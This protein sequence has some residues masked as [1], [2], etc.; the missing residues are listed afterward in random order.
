[1]S[2]PW[3]RR[4]RGTVKLQHSLYARLLGTKRRRRRW[5]GTREHH[6]HILRRV[7]SPWCPFACTGRECLPHGSCVILVALIQHLLPDMPLL[8]QPPAWCASGNAPW[9]AQPS[10]DA[11][12]QLPSA[13]W[14]MF[15]GLAGPRHIFPLQFL[16]WFKDRTAALAV[17]T[18]NPLSCHLRTPLCSQPTSPS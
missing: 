10:E 8:L 18:R 15:A 2:R 17:G 11:C 12:W 16:V 5:R 1:M 9:I 13:V 4:W 6:I 14:C 7:W 3:R